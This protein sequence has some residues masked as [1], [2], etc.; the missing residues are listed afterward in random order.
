MI[1]M[2]SRNNNKSSE[3]TVDEHGSWMISY[4]DMVTL[5]LAFFVLF[6]TVDPQKEQV[7]GLNMSLITE[8]K[9]S[10]D[11]ASETEVPTLDIGSE[12][13]ELGIS[14]KLINAW[15]AKVHKIGNKIIIEFPNVSFFD[16]GQITPRKE[17]LS[18]LKNFVKVYE[19]YQAHYTLGIR[20]FT[21]TKKVVSNLHRYKDNLELS[22]LRSISTMRV[23]QKEGIPLKL[24]KL[25][26]YGELIVT[27]REVEKLN[28]KNI[29]PDDLARTIMLVIE[30]KYK[31]SKS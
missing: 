14:E 7:D 15:G 4:G 24:M 8:L 11:I 18:I 25:G 13:Q 22:A 23:L 20:A 5:L 2:V 30:P 31:A 6:F 12:E 1:K 3:S 28:N 26:G 9:N 17:S 21:D 29:D 19:P 27:Q 16:V 10:R